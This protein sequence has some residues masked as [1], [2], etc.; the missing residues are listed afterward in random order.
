M[1]NLSKINVDIEHVGILKNASLSLK[2]GEMVG[3]IG[4]NGAGKLH[5]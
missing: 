1:L 4:R 5:C 3:L 2:Q